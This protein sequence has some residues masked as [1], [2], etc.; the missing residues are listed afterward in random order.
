MK[1][2]KL[3]IKRVKKLKQRLKQGG[4]Y[5]NL[6]SSD[7]LVEVML[8]HETPETTANLALGLMH[9][10]KLIK[11]KQRRKVSKETESYIR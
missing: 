8:E 6:L 5:I 11:E 10:L 1:K 7:G 3:K 4:N 9:S 2:K